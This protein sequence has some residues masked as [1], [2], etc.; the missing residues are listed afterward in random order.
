MAL[1]G[2]EG[3]KPSKYHLLLAVVAGFAGNNRE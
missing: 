3:C 1:G 2:W